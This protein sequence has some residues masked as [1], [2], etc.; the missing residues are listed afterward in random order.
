MSGPTFLFLGQIASIPGGTSG[1]PKKHV[2]YYFSWAEVSQLAGSR[3]ICQSVGPSVRRLV[4]SHG[5]SFLGRA[6]AD[7]GAV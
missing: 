6:D 1:E 7:V 2:L 5:H 4:W 3:S